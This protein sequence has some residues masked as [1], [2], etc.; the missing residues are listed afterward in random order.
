MTTTRA[1]STVARSARNWPDCAVHVKIFP[2]PGNLAESR[3]VLRVLQQYGE[4]VM[5]R[6][7]KYDAPNPTLNTALAIYRTRN[8][9]YNVIQASPIHFQLQQGRDGWISKISRDASAEGFS[10]R[11]ALDT[12][13]DMNEAPDEAIEV[14]SIPDA[15]DEAFL[16]EDFGGVSHYQSSYPRDEL[17]GVSPDTRT[18]P[19]DNWD[20]KLFHQAMEKEKI[21]RGSIE[22]VSFGKFSSSFGSP[23]ASSNGMM[24]RHDKKSTQQ[25]AERLLADTKSASPS[26]KAKQDQSTSTPIQEF[27]LS[28]VKSS[29]NHQAYIERQPYYAGFNPYMKTIMAEDL[30]GRVPLEGFLDF[31][32]NKGDVPLRI[33]LERKERNRSQTSLKEL[34]ET[35]KRERGEM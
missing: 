1:A 18:K 32:W 15:V 11:S 30:K 29:F 20:S 2:R 22:E 14:S 7:L 5:Y 26:P 24:K 35:G 27:H 33:R 17:G 4:V 16:S 10:P 23:Q 6:H 9:A 8:S 19:S 13:L 31:N 21:T 28:V 12:D 34:W 25:L 3:E